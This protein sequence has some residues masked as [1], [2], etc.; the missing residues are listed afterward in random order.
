[1]FFGMRLG[2]PA[3]HSLDRFQL[4]GEEI[5]LECGLCDLSDEISPGF[6][7]DRGLTAVRDNNMLL[8]AAQSRAEQS[9]AE[10]KSRSALFSC[11]TK[12]FDDG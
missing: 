7:M 6:L 3:D 1:M 11:A 10:L 5:Y 2:K 4:F 9:R 8:R 12:Y